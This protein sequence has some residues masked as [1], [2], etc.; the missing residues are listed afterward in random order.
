MALPGVLFLCTENSA[1]SQM[2]E[3]LLRHLASDRFVAFSAG[4]NPQPIHP[5]TR[6][7]MEEIGISLEGHRSKSFDE[8]WGTDSVRYAIMVCERAEKQCPRLW[9]FAVTRLNWYFPAPK[10]LDCYADDPVQ[11]FREVRDAIASRIT[12]WLDDSTAS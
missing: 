6:T 12:L 3:G 10:D 5:L 7:V 11:A 1:R 9:P 8:F 4:T 2:A